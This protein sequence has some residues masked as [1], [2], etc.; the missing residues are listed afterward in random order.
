MITGNIVFAYAVGLI[1]TSL[2]A[3]YL[4]FKL[5]KQ[6]DMTFDTIIYIL[7]AV[8]AGIVIYF[9]FIKKGR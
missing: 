9:I 5:K 6:G 1:M 7:A 3:I 4:Y 2:L 8:L